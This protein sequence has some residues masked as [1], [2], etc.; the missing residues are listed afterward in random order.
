[1]ALYKKVEE[2]IPNSY[3]VIFNKDVTPEA[4]AQHDALFAQNANGAKIERRWSFGDFH[5]Y[6][7]TIFDKTLISQIEQRPEVDFVEE[8]GMMYV[9]NPEFRQAEAPKNPC[10]P[11][12]GSTW[13]I[14]WTSDD[15]RKTLPTTYTYSQEN[16]GSGVTV[17]VIDTGIRVTH[18]EFGGR[19]RWGTNTIDSTK[20]DGNGHGTHCAGTIAGKTYGMA[21]DANVV[22]VKVLSDSGSGSTQSVISGI[23]WAAKD[24]ASSGRPG[25]G[26]LSLGGSQSTALNNA[27]NTAVSGGFPVVVAAGNENTNACTKS[28]AS[29]TSAISVGAT[30]SADKRTSFSNYGTCVHLFA[31]G[32]QI[33]SAWMGSDTA[34]NTISGTSMACPHVA[35]QC[36]KYLETNRDATGA[37][38]KTWLQATALNG[39]VGNP[40]AG[41]PNKSLFADCESFGPHE[42][43]RLKKRYFD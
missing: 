43:V 2:P 41:S 28:P 20:Q 14:A 40:G 27:V 21:K 39:V 36:A 8:D 29:A 12:S 15:V 30:D 9:S 11:Q 35:G 37:A 1:V 16:D 32:Y 34:T 22:A 5:G 26:S 25:L 19:A 4:I 3:L 10:Q 24:K 31:P 18:E 33:T 23:E 38:L 17:Y 13:G 7:A 6:G 42:T